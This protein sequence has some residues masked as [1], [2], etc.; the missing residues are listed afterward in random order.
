MKAKEETEVLTLRM[1]LASI[2][3]KEKEKRYKLAKGSPELGE[4]ELEAESRFVDEEIIEVIFSEVKKR[5]EAILEFEK[6][7]R[8][9]LVEKE[10]KEIEVLKRYLPEQLS[11]KEIKK[12]AIEAIEKIGAKELKDIGRVMGQLMPKLKGKAEGGVVSRI[13]RGLLS[14]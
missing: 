5:K 2:L 4:K 10:K 14:T 11:E 9:D 7:G 8:M 6:G 13:V 12:E 3:N 1:V